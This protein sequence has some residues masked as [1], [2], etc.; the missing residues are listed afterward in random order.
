MAPTS[1]SDVPSLSLLYK[2]KKLHP[3]KLG[4]TTDANPSHN[5]RIGLIRGDITSL[6]VGAIVNAANRSLLGGGGVDGAIHRAAGP[7]LLAE[8]RTLDG[9]ATGS[10]KITDAYELP[11][12]KVIHT[13]GPVYD[14]IHPSRSE[15][16]LRGCY[17]S[18]LQLAVENGLKSIAFSGI[19]TGIYG[20]PSMDAAVI[21]CDT[22]Q[23]F[24]DGHDGQ[25]LDKVIFVTFEDKDVNAY[26]HVLPR[27]FPPSSETSTEQKKAA[28]EQTAEAEAKAS[29][30]PSVPTTDPADAEH[31]PKKQKQ[32][33]ED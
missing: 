32:D 13:V 33:G 2:L 11:C 22:V 3:S 24:L 17:K 8:C 9:C 27:F 18:S 7:R 20:Y 28:E 10:S 26:N 4:P 16:A 23:K 12:N 29:Q 30:L 14:D 15:T 31:A 6:S 19:S 25:K 5:D 21:A 1:A